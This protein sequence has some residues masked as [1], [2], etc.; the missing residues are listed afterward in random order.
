MA[1]QRSSSDTLSA[2]E[3]AAVKE[4]AKELKAKASKEDDAK[5]CADAIAKMP[6]EDRKLAEQIHAMVTKAAPSLSPKTYYGMPAYANADGKV[7]CFFQPK[8]KFKVRYSTFG[9]ETA[10]LLD[11]G[12]MWPSAFALNALSSADEAKLAALVTKAAG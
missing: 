7:V 2:E 11:D 5:A 4:R 9:F 3:R 10:A 1:D 12:D 8:S 6:S